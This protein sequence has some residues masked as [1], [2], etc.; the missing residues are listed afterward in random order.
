MNGHFINPFFI[1]SN[2]ECP[3]CRK[4][5]ISKRSLRPDPNF[6]ALISKVKR[7]NFIF[8][9]NN[10]IILVARMYSFSCRY[11]PTG[12]SYNRF[13]KRAQ[14][15]NC[16]HTHQQCSLAKQFASNLY[17]PHVYAHT[18]EMTCTYACAYHTCSKINIMYVYIYVL[19]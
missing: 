1:Y 10:N 4:K 3:T 17:L 14:S 13:V 19:L 12:K 5:L 18:H 15:C 8:L 6:D 7:S 16:L 9:S 2:K 11:I